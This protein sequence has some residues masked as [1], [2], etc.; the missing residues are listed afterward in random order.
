M[1]R[2]V[3]V[4]NV[5]FLDDALMVVTM[6][7]SY[8]V[9]WYVFNDN[10][11]DMYCLHLQKWRVDQT[12]SKQGILPAAYLSNILPDYTASHPTRQLSP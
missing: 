1:Y 4:I 10:S 11:W 12:T 6:K 9:I 8:S 7:I 2:I 3:V 5:I